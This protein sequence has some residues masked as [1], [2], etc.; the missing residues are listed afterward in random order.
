MD[1]ALCSLE[2]NS[3][4]EGGEREMLLKYAGAYNP[5]LIIR[6]GSNTIEEIKANRQAIGYTENPKPFQTHRIN[7]NKGDNIF[8]FSDG[9]SDQFGGGKGK[10]MMKKRFK[11]LV[12]SLKDKQMGEQ[13][14]S[15][16]TYFENW[17]GEI[18]QVDDVCVMGV[19]V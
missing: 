2:L 16:N 10:K 7:L 9:F 1:I 12:I 3:P 14:K 18:E 5:L 11:E 15:I 6:D 17:R 8:L 19:R 13:Q 4:L